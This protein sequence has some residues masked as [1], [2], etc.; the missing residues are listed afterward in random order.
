[1]DIWKYLKF[2][3]ITTMFEF[4]SSLM[5]LNILNTSLCLAF[6]FTVYSLSTET[7]HHGAHCLIR[8]HNGRRCRCDTM[9]EEK[10]GGERFGLNTPLQ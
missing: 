6:S 4:C 8:G 1:M 2:E 3:R 9:E 5:S 7:G 10:G